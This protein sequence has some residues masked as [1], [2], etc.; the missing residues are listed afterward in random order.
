MR[1]S[2]KRVFDRLRRATNGSFR[3][4]TSVRGGLQQ[5]QRMQVLPVRAHARRQG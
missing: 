4:P 5:P 3:K 1:K 2:L